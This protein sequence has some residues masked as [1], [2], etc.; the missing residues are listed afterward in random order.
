MIISVAIGICAV[1]LPS[2]PK[3]QRCRSRSMKQLL[4]APGLRNY[5]VQRL[6]DRGF[7]WK[8]EQN[9]IGNFYRNAGSVER[10]SVMNFLVRWKRKEN[11]ILLFGR[12]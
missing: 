10:V 3:M 2:M 9:F 7:S 8:T 4:N 1:S 6:R 12:S 5:R 11:P